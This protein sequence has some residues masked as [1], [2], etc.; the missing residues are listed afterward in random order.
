MTGGGWVD[1]RKVSI[2]LYQ[3]VMSLNPWRQGQR[4]RSFLFCKY[5]DPI[6]MGSKVPYPSIAKLKGSSQLAG[7]TYIGKF[8]FVTNKYTTAVSR[9]GG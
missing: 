8:L 7:R 3:R 2:T 6:F 1:E 9:A 5:K 4:Q